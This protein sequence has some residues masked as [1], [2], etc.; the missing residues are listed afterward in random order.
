MQE[1]KGFM[2]V[3]VEMLTPANWNYKTDDELKQRKL[4]ENLKRNG[5]VETIIVRPLDTGFFEV[6]NGN[7]RL[8]AFQEIGTDVVHAFNTGK[9]TDAAAK[10]L[11]L[12]T[13][14]TRFASD[15]VR[16]AEVVKEIAEEFTTDDLSETMPF[17]QQ[18][19]GNMMEM[20]EFDWS[21]F[22]NPSE[23][24]SKPSGETQG[25]GEK[26]I[27]IVVPSEKYD[28]VKEAIMSA[29]AEFR[30]LIQVK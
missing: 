25:A 12:E 24:G 6:V 28:V 3:A 7:H 27:T 22:G 4:V 15:P 17:S 11:A 2:D 29:T 30:G 8:A 16:M 9:I 13:N 19:L 18:E 26:K 21:Q 10:R 23:G 14:E 5:Q 1:S 20:L